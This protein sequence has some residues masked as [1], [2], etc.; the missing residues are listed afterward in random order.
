M[1]AFNAIDL[2]NDGIVCKKNFVYSLTAAMNKLT[3]LSSVKKSN[4]FEEHQNNLYKSNMSNKKSQPN[5]NSTIND[6]INEN[7]SMK[8]MK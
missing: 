3:N 7:S 4:S 8:P 1:G 6:N 5:N 2:E